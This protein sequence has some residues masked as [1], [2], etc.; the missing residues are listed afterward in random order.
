MR[1]LQARLGH[2]VVATAGPG[3]A[4][5][6]AVYLRRHLG[7]AV[8]HYCHRLAA[9]ACVAVAGLV[10]MLSQAVLQSRAIATA[11]TAVSEE[12]SVRLC[13]CSRCS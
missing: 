6:V 13:L 10:D 8:S 7:C 4:T 12:C 2:A 11:T 5:A 9:A 1:H 3:P